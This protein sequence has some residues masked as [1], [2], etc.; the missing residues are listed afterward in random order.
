MPRLPYHLALD[1]PPRPL[2]AGF[3]LPRA[4]A[5]NH[6]RIFHAEEI[7]NRETLERLA[8]CGLR[9]STAA[10]FYKRAG[11][12]GI[13]HTD[14]ALRDGRWRRNVAAINWNLSGADSVMRWFKVG[15][16]GTM[17]DPAAAPAEG[18]WYRALNG[19]HFGFF[20]SRERENLPPRQIKVLAAA[21]IGSATLV[22]TDVPHAVENTDRVRGRWAL[23]VRF[24]PDFRTWREAVATL[25]PLWAV[26]GAQRPAQKRG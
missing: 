20:G 4:T 25:R 8:R 2:R 1:L 18:E 15:V 9:A 7:L 12:V 5:R 6:Y 21:A 13:V 26:A 14:V 19:I 17:P 3:R 10:L 24:E 11:S 16:R 22:R 23:S